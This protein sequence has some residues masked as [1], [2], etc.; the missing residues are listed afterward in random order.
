MTYYQEL[1]RK[2][3]ETPEWKD[4]TTRTVQTSRFLTG[5]ELQQYIDDNAKSVKKVFE[6]E[7]WNA[8]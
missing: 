5:D 2:V 4:Y 7:G 6:Q 8:S 3:S 1:L